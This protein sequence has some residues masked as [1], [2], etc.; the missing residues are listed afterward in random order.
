[1]TPIIRVEGFDRIIYNKREIKAALRK[2]GA[3]VRSEARRLIASRAISD[4]GD[5]PG[6]DSGAMSQ[7]IKVQAA[8]GGG[9]VKIQPFKTAAMG[10]EFY[11]AFLAHGTS[12]GLRPRANF[13]E[14]ALENKREAIR[15]AI[16]Q[17]LSDALTAA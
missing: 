11:P 2:G 12:R 6:Y 15:A 5:F 1:M 4:P 9:Y 10:A 16:T 17:A 14:T 8:S 3:I 7:S 13:M